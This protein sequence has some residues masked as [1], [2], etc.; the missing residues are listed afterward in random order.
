LPLRAALL[1]ALA[2]SFLG[3]AAAQ[4]E[5]C[6]IAAVTDRIWDRPDCPSGV[7]RTLLLRS[8]GTYQIGSIELR[9]KAAHCESGRWQQEAGR[10]GTIR[11][12]PCSGA[13]TTRPWA[14]AGTSLTFGESRYHLSSQTNESTAFIPCTV[15]RLCDGLSCGE[16]LGCL[17]DC[18]NNILPDP[19]CP[20]RCL[21]R[22]APSQSE[23][24]RLRSC[25]QRSACRDDACM[26]RA[27]AAELR[28]C[29]A[30]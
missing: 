13:A 7:C 29:T 10:C 27:C 25:A 2:A 26:E 23:L 11:L 19:A 22:V 8:D 3:P 9:S 24:T 16:Y 17:Q 1:V 14:V 30:R 28:A 20:S 21:E 12:E 4:P 18:G 6:G 15:R 5:R